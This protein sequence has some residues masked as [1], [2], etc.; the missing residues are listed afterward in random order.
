MEFP[1]FPYKIFFNS[2][3]CATTDPF[4]SSSFPKFLLVTS[5]ICSILVSTSSLGT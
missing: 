2:A 5:F 4:S 1:N 3:I